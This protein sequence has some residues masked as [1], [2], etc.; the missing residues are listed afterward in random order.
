MKN[1]N[2]AHKGTVALC[3]TDSVGR[4]TYAFVIVDGVR[5]TERKFSNP[6]AIAMDVELANRKL[7]VM[8]DIL[9]KDG[10]PVV[11]ATTGEVKQK[12]VM[13]DAP[14]HLLAVQATAM[15]VSVGQEIEFF[16]NAI[17]YSFIKGAGA[18]KALLR[19]EKLADYANQVGEQIDIVQSK[20]SN[21]IVQTLLVQSIAERFKAN[22]AP[23]SKQA[24]SSVSALKA[25]AFNDK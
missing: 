21:E 8:Q 10:K 14:A 25:D 20:V 9:D 4:V 1:F 15:P 7:P 16:T 18:N 12:E 13:Q 24:T 19:T 2:Q 23:K 22:I 17:G 5:N 11:D 6:D 3:T